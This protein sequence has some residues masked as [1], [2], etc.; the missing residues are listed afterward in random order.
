[1]TLSG[2][3]GMGWETLLGK[4]NVSFVMIRASTCYARAG[5]CAFYRVLG[6]PVGRMADCLLVYWL[7]WF[8]IS[9]VGRVTYLEYLPVLTPYFQT[10][11]SL[12]QDPSDWPY[13][14]FVSS[15]GIVLVRRV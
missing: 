5:C 12:T 1:M 13:Y 8:C 3:P 4:V 9:T 11:H 6:V 14:D 2:L 10:P 7:G 15:C